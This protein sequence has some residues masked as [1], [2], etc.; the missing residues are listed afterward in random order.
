MPFAKKWIPDP[1]NKRE[2]ELRK[3]KDKKNLRERKRK[4]QRQDEKLEKD[5]QL[6]S[7]EAEAVPGQTFFWNVFLHVHS[8]NTPCIS[9]H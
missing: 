1:L 6:W 7:T 2:L 8:I 4:N 5:A 3:L 9:R